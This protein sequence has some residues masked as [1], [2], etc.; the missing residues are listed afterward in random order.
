MVTV[1]GGY[2]AVFG[3]I[4]Q[5]EF[6]SGA[7]AVKTVN[8]FVNSPGSDCR[9][10]GTGAV[11]RYK[12]TSGPGN[13]HGTE[14]ELRAMV[15]RQG[16]AILRSWKRKQSYKNRDKQMTFIVRVMGFAI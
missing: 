11:S 6:R 7:V 1:Q 13:D 16:W 14:T 4:A 2:G 5:F 8:R 3:F 9:N 12:F 15:R 10:L